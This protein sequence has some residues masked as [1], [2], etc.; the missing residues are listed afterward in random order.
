MPDT[1]DNILQKLADEKYEEEK[2]SAATEDI[3]S[4]FSQAPLAPQADLSDPSAEYMK[5]YSFGR[6]SAQGYQDEASFR[7][8]SSRQTMASVVKAVKNPRPFER[9]GGA[10]IA[11]EFVPEVGSS[12]G[13]QVDLADPSSPDYDWRFSDE[14]LFDSQL[15][16]LAL[17]KY[18]KEAYADKYGSADPL[19]LWE[20]TKKYPG[21]AIALGAGAIVG[22]VAAYFTK[23]PRKICLLYTSDAA[24]D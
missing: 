19:T 4:D 15:Q 24:D 12:G 1:L 3:V 13:G 16:T 5:P 10:T 17:E 8:S 21:E 2:R 23:D 20:V 22:G 7:R 6:S 14:A 11:G 18:K 9:E